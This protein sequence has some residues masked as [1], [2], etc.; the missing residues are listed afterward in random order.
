[1]NNEQVKA[2]ELKGIAHNTTKTGT[3]DGQCEDLV[4]LRCKEGSW[5]TS[6]DGKQVYSMKDGGVYSQLFVHTNVYRHLLGVKGGR[7]YWFANIGA[8]GATF[9]TLSSPVAI[10]SVSGDLFITQTGHLLTIIDGSGSYVH[11]LFSQPSGT[12]KVIDADENGSVTSRKLYPFGEVHFNLDCEAGIYTDVNNDAGYIDINGYGNDDEISINHGG[13][14]GPLVPRQDRGDDRSAE[15]IWHTSIMNAYRKALENNRFTDPF[16]AIIA[17][18]LYDGSYIYASAPQMVYPRQKWQSRKMLSMSFGGYDEFYNTDAK[19]LFYVGDG[20]TLDDNK[21]TTAGNG[22]ASGIKS[23][24]ARIYIPQKCASSFADGREIQDICHSTYSPVFTI[25]ASTYSEA[26]S[27]AYTAGGM[28]KDKSKPL[29]ANV[30]GADLLLSIGDMS[31]ILSNKELFTG[32]GIFITKPASVFDLS[33]EGYKKG[34]ILYNGCVKRYQ[35]DSGAQ[36]WKFAVVNGS[37]SPPIRSDDDILYG[38]M[39]SPFYLLR[40]YSVSEL[41]NLQTSLRV[42][43]SAPEYKGVLQNIEQQPTFQGDFNGRATFLPK[44]AYSYNQRLHIANYT[45][46]LFHGYPLE[47]MLFNNHDGEARSG[48]TAL[49]INNFAKADFGSFYTKDDYVGVVPGDKTYHGEIVSATI[50]VFI[51]TD[52]GDAIVSRV[53][54]PGDGGVRTYIESLPPIVFY[55]DSRAYKMLVGVNLYNPTTGKY[56]YVEGVIAMEPHPLYDIA[57]GVFNKNLTPFHLA[58]LGNGVN[59]SFTFDKTSPTTRTTWNVGLEEERNATEDQPNAIK[60]SSTSNPFIFPAKNTYQVGSSEIM[61]LCSNAV[62]IGTGQTGAA[63]LY[64]F[65]KDGVYALLVDSSGEMVYTNS[66]IIARDVINQYNRATPID[67]GVVFTTDRGL[68]NVSGSEVE[69][70][71]EPLE[72]DYE[73]FASPSSAD[74]NKIAR[75]AYML[76]KLAGLPGTTVTQAGFLTYLQNAIVHYNHNERE[77]MVSNP[78]YDYSYVLDRFGNWTRRTFAADEYVNNYPTS[79]RVEDNK[80]YKVDANSDADNAVF[81]MSKVVKLDSI[82]FKELHRCVARGY[83]KTMEPLATSTGLNDDFGLLN[84]KEQVDRLF[85]TAD[86][87]PN[88]PGFV[89]DSGTGYLS[90]ENIGNRYRLRL[91]NSQDSDHAL[92]ARLWIKEPGFAGA[93][94]TLVKTYQSQYTDVCRLDQSASF[95]FEITEDMVEKP[96]EILLLIYRG[97]N[98][99]EK[100]GYVEGSIEIYNLCNHLGLYVFGSYDGRRWACLGHRERHGT[101]TDIGTLVE[102]TDC[103]YFRFVLAGKLDKQS[104][105]DYM[106]VSARDSKLS[107]KIR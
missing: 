72:G 8:D 100:I 6:G 89:I 67:G 66:R 61:A 74:Y 107:T 105:F 4:N 9:S 38:L 95:E 49:H 48:Y 11:A 57:I 68:M 84:N 24:R 55:P 22:F 26:H 45:K 12:Y 63:P 40:E 103:R 17:L 50:H 82:G 92:C 34:K 73:R 64:V 97:P 80:L 30:Y 78:R 44:V 15:L 88:K 23:T 7:L 43:L 31:L 39:H 52:D 106:E 77:L 83:F 36:W 65:C 27:D 35:V 79:Y 75:N 93:N 59:T 94:E 1:M 99:S 104:R 25:G 96:C 28:Y 62:A 33:E 76:T 2:I 5:R 91:Y 69:E 29:T 51:K 18:K 54:K 41:S 102:H 47:S 98:S 32:I 90:R 46:T 56:S 3:Q 70:L 101:F 20:W 16:M 19:P 58:K 81:V 71:G 60:V 14:S 10:C 86:D 21:Y 13:K 87:K 42:D 37:Y 53:M 85:S